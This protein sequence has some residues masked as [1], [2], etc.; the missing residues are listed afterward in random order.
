MSRVEW[1]AYPGE[2]VEQAI[3]VLL[4]QDRNGWHRKPGQGD[5]GVDVVKP[6]DDGRAYEVFQ[7]KGFTG[8]LAESN[9]KAQIKHSFDTAKDDPHLPAPM[10]AWHLVL[11]R[12][13]TTDEEEWF[14]DVLTKD[15]R[16]SCDWWGLTTVEDLASQH[17]HVTDWYFADGKER[18]ERRLRDLADAADLLRAADTSLRAEELQ[19]PVEQLLTA[20]NRE[21]PHYVYYFATSPTPPSADEELTHFEPAIAMVQAMP[22]P[23]DLGWYVIRTFERYA[24]ASADRP[25]TG[26]FTLRFPEG[27]DEA[28]RVRQE[29]EAA[30]RYGV[31]AHVPRDYAQQLQLDVPTG[32]SPAEEFEIRIGSR[33]DED[34]KPFELR[35]ALTDPDGVVLADTLVRGVERRPGGAGWAVK[36]VDDGGAFVLTALLDDPR[37]TSLEDCRM[38]LT[39]W[40]VTA[41]GEAAEKALPGLQLLHQLHAPNTLRIRP[42][43]G[44]TSDWGELPVGWSELPVELPL[45]RL[46]EAL[47][48]LQAHTHHV[49]RIPDELEYEDFAAV[50]EC[51]A[52]ID[53]T[54]ARGRWKP[55]MTITMRGQGLEQVV[56]AARPRRLLL[57]ERDV[58]L[59]LPETEIA[60]GERTSVLESAKL[61]SPEEVQKAIAADHRPD[62]FDAN[63]I[64][65]DSDAMVIYPCSP[66]ELAELIELSGEDIAICLHPDD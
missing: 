34:F 50:L 44:P 42:A 6:I 35:L 17:P 23:D 52:L 29:L 54:P 47:S 56:A 14:Y 24:G 41:I 60:I 28:A 40:R 18:Q 58:S 48:T 59:Q 64:P 5:H 12:D 3:A 1:G 63:L 15:A 61:E 27:D 45:V 53:G 49:L 4:L 66:D 25:I 31:D 38:Q 22:L 37:Q 55:P 39:E 43:Q 26:T 33:P 13:L 36:L 30:F 21:D 10:E 46:T 7:I 2:D 9:R 11:P 19:Q 8:R 62:V 57:H 65:G 51:A 20:V 32:S 16:F